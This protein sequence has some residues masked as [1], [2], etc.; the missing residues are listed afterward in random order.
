MEDG[1]IIM[2]TGFKS[3]KANVSKDVQSKVNKYLTDNDLNE[4]GD[5]QGTMYMGGTPLYNESTGENTDRYEHIL[6]KFP[7]LNK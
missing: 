6:K 3:S 2:P 7:N 1:K 4:Y 5:K